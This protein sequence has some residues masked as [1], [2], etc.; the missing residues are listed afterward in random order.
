MPSRSSSESVASH[1][2]P[3]RSRNSPV[4]EHSGSDFDAEAEHTTDCHEEK[5][6]HNGREGL[7]NALHDANAD[8]RGFKPGIPAP[9]KLVPSKRIYGSS[10]QEDVEITSASKT[11]SLCSRIPDTGAIEVEQRPRSSRAPSPEVKAELNEVNQLQPVGDVPAGGPMAKGATLGNFAEPGGK[12]QLSIADRDINIDDLAYILHRPL[13]LRLALLFH[14]RLSRFTSE[15]RSNLLGLDP[16]LI[17]SLWA[18]VVSIFVDTYFHLQAGKVSVPQKQETCSKADVVTLASAS[19]LRTL[20][21]K[22]IDP[23]LEG[24]DAK[25][26]D[27]LRQMSVAGLDKLVETWEYDL[28][29][30]KCH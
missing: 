21:I 20:A 11:R 7:E 16:S 19:L 4:V 3:S 12:D 14:T 24:L 23:V 29:F 26:C 18:P 6:S 22:H 8:F 5:E 30:V 25:E 1:S 10:D 15:E 13:L 17:A 27:H 9:R 2:R 28:K